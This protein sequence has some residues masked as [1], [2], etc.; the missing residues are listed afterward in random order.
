MLKNKD[1]RLGQRC[2]PSLEKMP[3]DI[4]I[5]ESSKSDLP[6]VLSLYVHLGMDDGAVLSQENA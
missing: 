5:R 1:S 3:I 4:V 2:I 6:A